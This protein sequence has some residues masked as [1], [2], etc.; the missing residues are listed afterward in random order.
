MSNQIAAAFK[1]AK[2]HLKEIN[3]EWD[4]LHDKKDG[5]NGDEITTDQTEDTG[6]IVGKDVEGR[7]LDILNDDEER[8]LLA[9]LQ[10][11]FPDASVELL[12]EKIKR[13]D[14]TGVRTYIFYRPISNSEQLYV[15]NTIGLGNL[16]MIQVNTDHPL[17]SKLLNPLQQNTPNQSNAKINILT[18]FELL[19]SASVIEEEK[20]IQIE[21]HHKIIKSFRTQMAIKLSHFVDTLFAA[22]PN[23]ESDIANMK[24]GT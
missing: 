20:F 17:Y 21:D 14:E 24:D 5:T 3:S 1:D 19:V 11:K 12:R 9:Y 4:M 18:M 15:Y 22:Y 6:V 10:E 16:H 23:I 8:Q 2:K 13:I 7:R